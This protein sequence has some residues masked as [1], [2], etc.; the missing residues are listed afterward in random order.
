VKRND[1]SVLTASLDSIQNRQDKW[2]VTVPRDT[3]YPLYV[4]SLDTNLFLHGLCPQTEADFRKGDGSELND[5]KTRPAKMRALVSSSALAV[6]FFDP[7]R[8]ETLADLGAALSL[9][10][11]VM[12]L[13]FEYKPSNYPVKP[14]SPNLDLMLTLEDGQRVAVE[15]KFAEP[16]RS[17][18]EGSVISGR[19]FPPHLALWTEAGLDGA[20][21]LA[22]TLAPSWLHLDVAQLLKHM[23][24][25]ASENQGATSLLYLWYD[26]GMADGALHRQEISRFAAIVRNDR[27]A[28]NERSYQDVFS[29]IGVDQQP[30]LGWYEYMRSRYFA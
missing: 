16:Y 22:N 5:A 14:R 23:L 12:S 28:F 11:P 17:P 8:G 21:A 13:H 2:A 6:N 9:N 1:K 30:Q 10:A 29:A 7:W 19:Y 4:R 26:S 20:Q 24:G 15:S 18:G 27:V 3:K 25:L